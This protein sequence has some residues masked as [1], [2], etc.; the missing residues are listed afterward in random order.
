MNY[1]SPQAGLMRLLMVSG[2]LGISL[3]AGTAGQSCAVEMRFIPSLAVSEE[4]NDNI[5]QTSSNKQTDYIT[6][7]TPGATFH[8][9]TPFWTWDA[10]DTFDY[11]KYAQKSQGD[12]Y[13]NNAN[14]AGKI[15]L[16]D[17]F[18]FLDVSDAYQRVLL[19]V[20]QDVATQSSLFLNQTDQNIA[21]VSPYLLWRL[22]EK[23]TL[24][25]GYRYTDTRYWGVGIE[26]REH[27]AFAD[28]KYEWTPKFSLSAGYDFA[29]IET[30]LGSYDTHDVYG[31][32]NYQYAEK[33]SIFGKVGNTWQLFDSGENVSFLFWDAGIIHDLG[34]AVATLETS[35]QTSIDPL[36][37]ASKTTTYSG[38]LDK[39]LPRGA[40]GFSGSYSVF[41]NTQAGVTSQRKLNFSGNGRYE[42]WENL[43]ATLAVTAEHY[44]EQSAV[45]DFRYHLYATSGLIYSLNHDITVSLNY[46]YETDRNDLN[47]ATGAIEINRGVVVVRKS[48]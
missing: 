3:V 21:T 38:K 36:A 14:L 35:V 42:V 15:T 43:I 9:L 45:T 2:L 40:V 23:S 30:I 33:S 39:T 37:G 17:N 31:G 12:Q 27:D 34:I 5:Y 1:C 10:A 29:R 24:K 28:F 4:I 26:R 20:A 19:N 11:S 22:G 6:H 41:E 47:D 18:L 25:T 46:T 48:F 7:V 16:L 44:Y 13:I 8:Y 32:F